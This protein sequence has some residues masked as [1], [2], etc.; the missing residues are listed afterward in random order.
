MVHPA[1]KCYFKGM[2]KALPCYF[3]IEAIHGI[4]VSMRTAVSK[5]D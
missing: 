5:A 1:N 4:G 2:D 3:T